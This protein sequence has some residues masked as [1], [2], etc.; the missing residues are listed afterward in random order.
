MIF[1][2]LQF[3]FR[4]EFK[5]IFLAMEIFTISVYLIEI[6]MRIMHL[7]SDRQVYP[8]TKDSQAIEDTD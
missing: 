1:I 8:E 2:P 3:G 6:G 4:I 7:K 5:G